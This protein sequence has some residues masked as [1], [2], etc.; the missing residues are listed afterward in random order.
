MT[1]YEILNVSNSASSNEILIA[2]RKLAKQYHPDKNKDPDAA[3]KFIQIYEAYKILSNPETKAKYDKL[4]HNKEKVTQDLQLN[5]FI[6]NA[7]NEGQTFANTKYYKTMIKI[8]KKVKKGFI[9]TS[10]FIIYLFLTIIIEV[11][12]PLLIRGIIYLIIGAIL[13]GITFIILKYLK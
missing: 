4:L 9:E 12:L 1:Y 13:F 6:K 3:T 5:D 2:F 11:I 10:L 8:L 7:K